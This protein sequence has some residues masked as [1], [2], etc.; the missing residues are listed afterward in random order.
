[1]IPT[2]PDSSAPVVRRA[3]DAPRQA[4][5]H[6]QL[7]LSEVVRQAA[8][9]TARRRRGVA[10]AD[11]RDRLPVEQVEVALRDQQRRRVFQLGKQ[12]R[13]QPLPKRQEP[14]PQLLHLRDLALGIGAR[15]QRGRFAPS[16]P[17]KVWHGVERRSR[18]SE[19]GDQLTVGDRPDAGRPQQPQADG[20]VVLPIRG[21]VPFLKRRIFSR[22]F[23][24]TSNAKPSSIL[25]Y[26]E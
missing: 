22:C 26:G 7:V 15:A 8:R 21:S 11:D 9:K 1:M 2:V 25:K 3:V 13:I 23:H 4:R 12:P 17:G 20:E 5:D 24:R 10:R 6:H 14:G 16:A 18:A 19:A